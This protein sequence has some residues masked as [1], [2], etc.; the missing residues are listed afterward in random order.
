M[1]WSPHEMLCLFSWT[2]RAAKGYFN[3]LASAVRMASCHQQHL[4]G[5]HL[6]HLNPTVGPSTQT[7]SHPPRHLALSNVHTRRQIDSKETQGIQRVKR[8][9]RRT[10]G[11]VAFGRNS[12]VP[13]RSARGRLNLV[14]SI[15][16]RLAANTRETPE[17]HA[18]LAHHVAPKTERCHHR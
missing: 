16:H 14:S 1:Q 6:I 2:H 8:Q 18:S 9:T 11:D 4:K 15:Q 10:V 13:Q 5:K 17:M 3:V 7:S 12:S